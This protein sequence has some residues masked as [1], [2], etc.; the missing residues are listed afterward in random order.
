MNYSSTARVEKMS[1]GDTAP[2]VYHMWKGHNR[3]IYDPVLRNYTTYLAI[4]SRVTRGERVHITYRPTGRDITAQV[5]LDIAMRC[6]REGHFV[7]SPV[8]LHELLK[9]AFKTAEG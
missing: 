5:L 7:V 1:T 4:L 9:T 3:R 2:L 6:T 8:L